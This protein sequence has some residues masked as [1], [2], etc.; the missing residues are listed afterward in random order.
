M[1]VMEN[2]KAH[3]IFDLYQRNRLPDNPA[4]LCESI[5]SWLDQ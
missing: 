1:L 3:N 2:E 4:I 5:I